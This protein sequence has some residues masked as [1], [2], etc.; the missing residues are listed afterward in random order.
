[1]NPN[2]IPGISKPS[3]FKGTNLKTAF[4]ITVTGVRRML[5]LGPVT[6][7]NTIDCGN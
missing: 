3:W 1:L 6:S 7:I 5:A 4:G 2:F